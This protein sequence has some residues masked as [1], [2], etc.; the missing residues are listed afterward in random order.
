MRK[1]RRPEGGQALVGIVL[2]MVVLAL[3]LLVALD[4]FGGSKAKG[5]GATPP[6]AGSS[7]A[8]TVTAAGV[9]AHA[10]DVALATTANTI[11]E[12][13]TTLALSR[14]LGPG[15]VDPSSSSGATFLEVAAAEVK[16]GGAPATPRPVGG[17]RY[18][19]SSNGAVVCITAPVTQSG[20]GS[21]V[22]GRC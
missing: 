5:H 11:L 16:G 1:W 18:E 15:A 13:A 3:M 14:G 20:E 22:R 6:G 2:A 19:L 9:I 10:R 21:V 12:Q 4:G 8:G 7:A 17:D